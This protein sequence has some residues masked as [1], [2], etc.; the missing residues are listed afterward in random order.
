MATVE[1]NFRFWKKVE[2]LQTN[3]GI[4]ELRD[5]REGSQGK[6]IRIMESR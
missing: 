5:K 4:G 2:S 3:Q 6:N 1:S